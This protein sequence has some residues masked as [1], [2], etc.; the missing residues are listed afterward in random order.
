MIT[1][2]SDLR[3][4]AET[5]SA[6]LPALMLSAER[7]AAM[8]APGAHGLRRAGPGEDFWQ[9]RPASIG[10]S[11]R[12]IDWR[13]SARSDTQFVRDQEAQTA[14]TAQIWLSCHAGMEFTGGD[15]R[16]TKAAMGR[17][18]S[19]ALAMLLLRGGEN[20]GMLGASIGRGRLQADR[21]ASTLCMPDADAAFPEHDLRPNR[22]VI[23]IADFLSDPSW[24]QSFLTRAAAVGVSGILIQLLDPDEENFPFQGAVEFRDR[25]NSE[26][27][28]SRDA[29]GLRAQYLQRLAER[30]DLLRQQARQAGWQFDH[31][32]T[33]QDPAYV[34][35]RIWTVLGFGGLR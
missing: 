24:V 26:R 33:S 29:G 34:L 22:R 5:A 21:I 1:R 9:Y 12:N 25:A 32:L 2:P 20:V 31:Y 16:P 3:A 28:H 23:V 35:G 11:S 6:H 17:V 30:R 15:D 4:Q 19:L 13:R 7:L 27:H 18:L 14:Q 8:I 10:D